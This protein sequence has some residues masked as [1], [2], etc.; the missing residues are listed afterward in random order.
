[1]S[2]HLVYRTADPAVA[3][4]EAAR[5]FARHQLR[6]IDRAPRFDAMAGV[7]DLS[8]VAVNYVRFG[9]AVQIERPATDT[10]LGLMVPLAGRLAVEHDGP[11]FTASPV[12]GTGVVLGPGRVRMSWTAD[13]QVLSFRINPG[14]IQEQVRKLLPGADDE[15][16]LFATSPLVGNGLRT[17]RALAQLAADTFDSGASN[18]KPP[19]AVLAQLRDAV[20]T[21]VLLGIPSTA[22][23]RILRQAP[24]RR[25]D[26]VQAAI[27][28]IAVEDN[29]ELSLGDIAVRAGVGLRA[30]ELGFRHELDMTPSQYL[31]ISRLQRARADLQAAGPSSG[32]RVG[33]VAQ[34]WGF[35]HAG[36]FSKLY[37]ERFGEYPSA[38]LAI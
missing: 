38:S 2:S 37:F 31:R 13:C 16:A 34:K 4:R 17:V 26:S 12:L 15:R 9:A 33:E 25:R 22:A 30:L 23:A 11:K 6:V 29:G 1:L 24:P 14:R 21:A 10:Y 36:R 7:G 18:T 27:D 5:L 3:S 28:L 32:I 19:A 8:G 35:F 20:L